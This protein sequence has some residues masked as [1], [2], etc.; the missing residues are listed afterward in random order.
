M[1][2]KGILNDG[3]VIELEMQALTD[4]YMTERSLYYWARMYGKLLNAGDEYKS[5]KPAVSVIILGVNRLKEEDYWHNEYQLLNIKSKK[6]LT[7]DLR[8]VFLELPKLH[9]VHVD[10]NNKSFGERILVVS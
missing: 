6:I 10:R 2:I 4:G 5:L 7:N 3:T 8:I 9:S 1:D